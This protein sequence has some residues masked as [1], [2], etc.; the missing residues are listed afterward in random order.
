[1]K[2]YVINL[3][4]AK[5]RREYAAKQLDSAGIH[6]EF[7]DAIRGEVAIRDC[8]FE[9]FDSERFRLNTGRL[10][11]I[12]ELGCF[13]SHRALWQ[14]CV[15]A[16]EPVV[17][18]E[19]DF[20]ILENFPDA[21]RSCQKL[22]RQLGWIRLQAT[23]RGKLL[24]IGAS[25]E[26]NV[27]RYR[28]VPFGLMCYCIS[29]EVAQRFLQLTAKVEAPVD[30]FT[31]QFWVHKQPMFA[32]TPY[33]VSPSI[34]SVESTIVG[35]LKSRKSPGLTLRRAMHKAT[36]YVRRWNFNFYLRFLTKNPLGQSSEKGSLSRIG[37]PN[38][39]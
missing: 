18:M 17:V 23:S 38:H 20:N 39:E 5:E 31:K 3:P 10:V 30:E 35:R 36:L 12:G 4:E 9:S 37:V 34:M 15:D 32:L 21:L 27:G 14:R 2:V 22:I 19:D 6:F 24:T 11:A 8:Y 25:E 1:M 13:A 33:S 28:K 29:P 7:F 26:F 16:K